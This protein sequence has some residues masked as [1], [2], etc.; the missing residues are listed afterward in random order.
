[1]SSKAQCHFGFKCHD[2]ASGKCRFTHPTKP[3]HP[4]HT[5]PKHTSSSTTIICKYG[6]HCF[7]RRTGKCTFAHPEPCY[8]GHNGAPCH[9][10]HCTKYHDWNLIVSHKQI[11]LSPQHPQPC[12]GGPL[13]DPCLGNR[14]CQYPHWC[15]EPSTTCGC[16]L[17]HKL[18][19]SNEP[20]PPQVHPDVANMVFDTTFAAHQYVFDQV[21]HEVHSEQYNNNPIVCAVRS[22]FQPTDDDDTTA[23]AFIKATYPLTFQ[24]H[25]DKYFHQHKAQRGGGAGAAATKAIISSSSSSTTT[26]LTLIVDAHF[27]F[28]DI[29]IDSPPKR[30]PKY[31]GIDDHPLP[32]LAAAFFFTYK[33]CGTISA[34]SMSSNGSFIP[35]D[36][37]NIDDIS[38][39]HNASKQDKIHQFQI[40]F[41]KEEDYNKYLTQR[42]MLIDVKGVGTFC[43]CAHPPVEFSDELNHFCKSLTK[44]YYKLIDCNSKSKE[45]TN[46]KD[47]I[48]L[49]DCKYFILHRGCGAFWFSLFNALS[50]QQTNCPMN[51]HIALHA[52]NYAFANAPL[53]DGAFVLALRP[54]INSSG[55]ASFPQAATITT[56]TLPVAADVY[57]RP[58]HFLG[59]YD[60]QGTP[61][62]A[63][64]QETARARRR[65]P[66]GHPEVGETLKQAAMREFEEELGRK[67]EL[68]QDLPDITMKSFDP[69][70]TYHLFIHTCSADDAADFSKDTPPLIN[71]VHQLRLSDWQEVKGKNWVI[72]PNIREEASKA[73]ATLTLLAYVWFYLKGPEGSDFYRV[74]NLLSSP[75]I[76][77]QAALLKLSQKIKNISPCKALLRITFPT[78]DAAKIAYE[79]LIPRVVESCLTL[80]EL[81]S[82]ATHFV[83]EFDSKLLEEARKAQQ[84]AGNHNSTR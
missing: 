35:L 49:G 39:H 50:K 40:Q 42:Y 45:E 79:Q 67:I 13:G 1:M 25:I 18:A 46:L 54:G 69:T 83:V 14:Y 73:H 21:K 84:L 37:N 77:L 41:E 56:S 52:L 34:S 31:P 47:E 64:Y 27:P 4:S 8:M 48:I 71:N 28:S 72:L 76:T 44:L 33:D 68:H 32:G 59:L 65:L 57:F 63:T 23:L 20:N 61:I 82:D 16:S 36:E 19:L 53:S 38:Q 80:G 9:N 17:Y 7:S 22:F 5:K 62:P 30:V 60:S 15:N 29:L 3:D 2:R 70:R 51:V 58:S 24:S 74:S 11:F 75:D 78:H 10:P 26:P 81:V 6:V 43:L 66:G 12:T 55:D